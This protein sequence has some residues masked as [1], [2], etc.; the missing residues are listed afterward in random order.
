[1][2]IV[3]G[4]VEKLVSIGQAKET[5]PKKYIYQK[6]QGELVIFNLQE[7]SESMDPIGIVFP[8]CIQDQ[9][10]GILALMAESSA[11]KDLTTE[12]ASLPSFVPIISGLLA[13]VISH[14]KKDKKIQMLNLYQTVSSSMAWKVSGDTS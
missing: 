9:S 13:N 14:E 4:L 6:K 3:Q 1:M 11:I 7:Y 2:D 12:R 8:L 5:A 10:L